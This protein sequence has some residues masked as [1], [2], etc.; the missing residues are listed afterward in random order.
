MTAKTTAEVFF[1]NFAVHYGMPSRLHPDQGANFESRIIR[2]L[3]QIAGYKK[4]RTP[5]HPMGNGM[6]ERFN[7]TLLDTLLTLIM[8]V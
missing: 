5:Y 1:S 8:F 3:C 4:S 7:R 6:C 2:E